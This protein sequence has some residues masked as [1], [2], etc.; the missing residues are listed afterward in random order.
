MKAAAPPDAFP[1]LAAL[2]VDGHDPADPAERQLALRWLREYYAD[3]PSG[4]RSGPAT[5]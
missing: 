5:G 3:E 1:R 2:P 4:S